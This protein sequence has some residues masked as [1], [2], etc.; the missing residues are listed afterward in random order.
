[1]KKKT[2]VIKLAPVLNSATETLLDETETQSNENQSV[3][4]RQQNHSI[5]LSLSLSFSVSLST[6][7][8]CQ[9]GHRW[10]QQNK[11]R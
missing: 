6:Q 10:Q 2:E 3:L 8:G 9:I 11:H 5:S 7:T 1:M 4:V